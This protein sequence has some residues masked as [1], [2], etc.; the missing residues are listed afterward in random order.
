MGMGSVCAAQRLSAGGAGRLSGCSACASSPLPSHTAGRTKCTSSCAPAGASMPPGSAS[1]RAAK[2]QAQVGLVTVVA[3]LG[4]GP[5][6]P[7]V[8][9]PQR[10][11]RAQSLRFVLRK[12]A[13]RWPQALRASVACLQGTVRRSSE[14]TN[15]NVL[16]RGHDQ[17]T[18]F[19][20]CGS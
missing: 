1:S 12:A 2:P 16:I 11:A 9:V 14:T 10:H 4:H 7:G 8:Q 19:P 13:C 18:E 20:P 6:R 15:R 3:G 17:G 5:D